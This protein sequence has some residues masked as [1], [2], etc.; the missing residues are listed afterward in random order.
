MSEDRLDGGARPPAARLS[1]AVAVVCVAMAVTAP[2]VQERSTDA[3]RLGRELASR[4]AQAQ[5]TSGFQ[6][7]ARVVVGMESEQGPRPVV[8]QIR[9]LGR[10]E[11]GG[12]RMLFQVLWPNALKGH[13]AVVERRERPPVAGFLFDPPDRVTPL[14]PALVTGPFAGTG[15]T[16][17]DLADDFWRWPSQ[18]VAGDG[19]ADG[20]PCTL[21]ESQ[22]SREAASAYAL[23]RSCVDA[24]RAVPRWVEKR[25][26]DGALLKRIVF[27]RRRGKSRD[28]SVSL[29]MV[30]TGDA[31]VAPTRV[32]FLKSER[33]VSVPSVEFT[34]ERLGHLGA[35]APLD[36]PVGH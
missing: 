9:F 18:R 5:D 29:A 20:Q 8:L 25:G 27:E 32:E 36:V 4:V 19:K 1:A 26:P 2:A 35:K 16:L 28:E 33:D 13:A 11:S 31:R 24:K 21:L 10:R 12:M 22:P 14:T 17:E 3:A 30:V 23:V 15:L 7:R 6:A 34:P